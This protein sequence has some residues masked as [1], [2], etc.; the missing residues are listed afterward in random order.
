MSA[1]LKPHL[2]AFAAL[3]EEEKSLQRSEMENELWQEDYD[4]FFESFI[5]RYY[6]DVYLWEVR[7]TECSACR[8]SKEPV[9]CDKCWDCECRL[10]ELTDTYFK[11]VDWQKRTTN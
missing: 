8:A 1:K 7:K 2:D 6:P 5:K 3:L 10:S 11:I 9:G 4:F